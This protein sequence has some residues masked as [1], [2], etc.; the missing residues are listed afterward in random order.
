MLYHFSP[1]IIF[2]YFWGFLQFLIFVFKLQPGFALFRVGALHSRQ[3]R[4]GS[5]S[6][7]KTHLPRTPYGAATIPNP[8][9]IPSKNFIYTN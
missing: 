7:T 6:L 1:Q 5:T 9:Y 4:L 2:F 8:F 3:L